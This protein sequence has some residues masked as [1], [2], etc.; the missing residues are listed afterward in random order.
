MPVA[1][2]PLMFGL[3]ILA[4]AASP[5]A[6]EPQSAPMDNAHLP[7]DTAVL[8]I[9]LA[10]AV[11]MALENNRSL[12]V[13]RLTPEIIQSFEDEARSVFDPVLSAGGVT[14][15]VVGPRPTTAAEHQVNKVDEGFIALDT[16]FPTGTAL[17][18]EAAAGRA[19]AG[20]PDDGRYAGRLGMALNQSLLQGFGT[21]VNL[22]RLRQARLETQ[23]S[24]YELQGFSEA[25]VAGVEHAYWDYAL[26]LR[27]IEIV[28]ESLNLAEQQLSDTRAMIDVGAMAEAELPAVQAEVA[29][30]RQGLIDAK[31]AVAANR[32]RLLQLVNP[33]GEVFDGELTLS[34]PPAIPSVQLDPV[35]RSVDEGL[36]RRPEMNQARLEIDRGELEVVRT[37]NGLLP[38]LDLFVQ[39]G[40]SGYADAFGSAFSELDGD[41]YDAQAGIR[42]AYPLFNREAKARHRRAR[43]SR[44][45]AEKALDNLRQLVAL[46][47]R[48]AHLEVDRTRE[49]IGASAA[50]RQWQEEKLRIET[51]KFRVG[52]STNLLVAQAQ[53][54][55]LV[56]RID[57][58]R[59]VV[60]YLKALT[61]LYR[62]EGTLLER[63]GIG[64]DG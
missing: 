29:L 61:D 50:T 41:H 15:R 58:V 17:T 28:R 37:R 25:L 18:L 52:R 4:L 39:L 14:Q 34:H 22:A 16:Y 3:L 46:D 55:L 21:D 54:D 27:Q 40:K 26:T 11:I 36:R 9:T 1:I 20:R 45:Q 32:L 24:R 8:T 33:P 12:A 51:E 42:L 62:F 13:E 35:G 60:A 63:R 30:Q 44:E 56:S 49:Q 64:M 19:D 6:A 48:I 31:N 47:I 23:I 7:D 59:A 43:L 5:V 2:R 57:E 10:D 38:R 53:R